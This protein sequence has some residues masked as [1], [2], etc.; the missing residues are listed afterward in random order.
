MGWVQFYRKVTIY[1]AGFVGQEDTNYYL[2]RVKEEGQVYS[3]LY[4]DALGEKK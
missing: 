4:D 1:E 3:S 2:I